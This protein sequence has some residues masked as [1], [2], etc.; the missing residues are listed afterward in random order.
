M[1][2]VVVV[3][4]ISAV[5]RLFQEWSCAVGFA[6]RGIICRGW[7]CS[8]TAGAAVRWVALSVVEG[9]VGFEIVGV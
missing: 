7:W 3:I 8:S 9:E 4:G 6:A 1:E 5:V 2:G